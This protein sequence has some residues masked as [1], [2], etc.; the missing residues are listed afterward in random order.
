MSSYNKQKMVERSIPGMNRR[1]RFGEVE[2][3]ENVGATVKRILTY[4]A[5]EKTMVGG[6]LAIVIFGTFCGVYAPS[7]QSNAIDII[8]G[9][10][11]GDLFSAVAFMLV[12]YVLYSTSQLLQGLVSA[13]L[14][15]RIVCLLYTSRCV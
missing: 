10:R 3:A 15:Q 5:Q 11:T 12:V 8:A 6:M 1:E 2:H 4:F 9:A 14:S 7:L 13:K